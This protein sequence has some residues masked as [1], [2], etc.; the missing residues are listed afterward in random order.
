M[1][2]KI[3]QLAYKLVEDIVGQFD[4]FQTQPKHLAWAMMQVE[5]VTRAAKEYTQNVRESADF[6]NDKDS[7]LYNAAWCMI[8]NP[9]GDWFNDTN[10][11]LPLEEKLNKTMDEWIELYSNP[12]FRFHELAPT[13]FRVKEK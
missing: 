9:Q 12:G 13:P 8:Y 3:A 1:N 11:T 2:K 10:P 4:Y 7:K 6:K 5:L